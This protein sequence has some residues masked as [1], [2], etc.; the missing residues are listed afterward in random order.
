MNLTVKQLDY[1]DY[2]TPNSKVSEILDF[3]NCKIFDS[4]LGK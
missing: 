4:K 2:F 1:R 3:E